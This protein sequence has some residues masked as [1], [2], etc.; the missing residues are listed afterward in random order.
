MLSQP[1]AAGSCQGGLPAVR[2]TTK[3]ARREN[4]RSGRP[5]VGLVM[6]PSWAVGQCRAQDALLC[7][8]SE[9]LSVLL[10]Q[11][12]VDR[13]APAVVCSPARGKLGRMR[14]APGVAYLPLLMGTLRG[15]RGRRRS[16]FRGDHERQPLA[17]PGEPFGACV[18][19][20]GLGNCCFPRARCAGRRVSWPLGTWVSSASSAS[21]GF[22]LSR[23]VVCIQDKM[24][25][26]QAE[27]MPQ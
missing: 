18:Q 5:A 7:P 22:W 3:N 25:R 19:H 10:T 11:L 15:T 23:L 20:L 2:A 14:G 13:L 27:P 1:P 26:N 24:A 12:S 8:A 4:S 9:S 6:A 16:L 21:P 17:S